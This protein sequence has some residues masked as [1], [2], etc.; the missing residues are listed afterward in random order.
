MVKYV[1]L[2]VLVN[3]HTIQRPDSST[4]RLD[5]T[6]ILAAHGARFSVAAA[7]ACFLLSD[8]E[9]SEPPNVVTFSLVRCAAAACNK[10][11]NIIACLDHK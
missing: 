1:F 7:G 9:E 3:V 6:L 8:R 5:S 4:E 11:Q 10:M 2:L